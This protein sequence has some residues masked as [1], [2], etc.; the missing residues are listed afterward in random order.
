MAHMKQ[1]T[2]VGSEMSLPKMLKEIV[3]L[4]EDARKVRHGAQIAA[5]VLAIVEL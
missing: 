4:A 2:Y 5:K 3:L 1:A